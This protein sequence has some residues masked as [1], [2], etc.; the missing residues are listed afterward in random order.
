MRIVVMSDSHRR[1]SALL[2]IIE[3]HKDNADLFLFLGDGNDD[4]D[5]AL[6]MYPDINLDSTLQA[7]L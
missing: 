7:K 5:E 6:I 3:R 4:L 2:D 1:V